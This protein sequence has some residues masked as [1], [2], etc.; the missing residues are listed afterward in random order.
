[1]MKKQLLIIICVLQQFTFAQVSN[2]LNFINKQ[3]LDNKK[4]HLF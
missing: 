4:F 1:M 3:Q 2:F